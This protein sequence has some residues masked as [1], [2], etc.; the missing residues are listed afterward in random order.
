M[1]IILGYW[2][3]TENFSSCTTTVNITLPSAKGWTET[4]SN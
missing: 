4:A 1:I 3:L 2:G